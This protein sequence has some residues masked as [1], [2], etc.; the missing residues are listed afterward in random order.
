MMRHRLC[1]TSIPNVKCGEIVQ[2]RCSK[3]GLRVSL[4]GA[5]LE[6]YE[7]WGC[8]IFAREHLRPGP[9]LLRP[10]PLYRALVVQTRAYK[11]QVMSHRKCI[12][13]IGSAGDTLA[14]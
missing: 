3:Q 11:P 7:W 10:S 9:L 8:V 13:A 14:L 12:S 6:I 4:A 2:S 1:G 5:D